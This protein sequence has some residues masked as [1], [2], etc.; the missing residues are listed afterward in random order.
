MLQ[1]LRKKKNNISETLYIKRAFSDKLT[2]DID[3]TVQ[4][5][6]INTFCR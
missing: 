1:S 5:D 6:E 3:F 2:P 4:C